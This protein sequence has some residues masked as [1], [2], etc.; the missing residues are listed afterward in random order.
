MKTDFLQIGFQKCGTTFLENNVYPL[1]PNIHCIQAAGVLELERLLLRNL[2]LPDGLEYRQDIIDNALPNICSKLFNDKT[3]N[4]IMFE[5]FTFSYGR[6]FDRKNVI[7]R[8]KNI[9]PNIKII[10]F[11]RNQKTW[12]L[13]HY[14]QY[15]KGGGLLSLHDFIECFF[16]IHIAKVITLIGTH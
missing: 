15:L 14:A 7:D 2:I 3:V 12:I 9:F 4:G 8:I 1:N 13:S 10:T 16:A 5:P 6:R 11:I